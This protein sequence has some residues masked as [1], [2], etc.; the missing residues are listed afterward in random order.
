M[1]AATRTIFIKLEPLG[2]RLLVLGR[3]VVAL[4]A[5]RAGE[6]RYIADRFLCHDA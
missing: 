1:L 3:G 2:V 6:R 5:H 4:F